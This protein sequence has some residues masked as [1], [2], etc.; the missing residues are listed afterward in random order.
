MSRLLIQTYHREVEKI[1]QY[2]GSRKE[3]SI[4]VA[5][6]KLLESYC[7]A[8]HFILIPELA[9]RT[10]YDTTVYPD[11][12]IKD[13]L[14]LPWG[15]WDRSDQDEDLDKEIQNKLTKGYPNDNILFED[16]QTAVLIQIGQE[17]Q[18][19]KMADAEKLEALL[20]HFIHYERPEVRDFRQAIEHFKTDLPTILETLRKNARGSSQNESKISSGF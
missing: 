7:S 3:T 9:Y 19:V 14:R 1:I 15:Y 16:S 20:T 4:R 18:R 17:V 13:A 10:Q 2:S 8:N 11:G 12:T 6:Q 5:F